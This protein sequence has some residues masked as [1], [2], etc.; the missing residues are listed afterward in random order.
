MLQRAFVMGCVSLLQ[1]LSQL[2]YD[3]SFP[4][5]YA[6]LSKLF[7]YILILFLLLGVCI[8]TGHMAIC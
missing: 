6:L 7:V 3:A 4:L 2:K 5:R 1:E 8:L